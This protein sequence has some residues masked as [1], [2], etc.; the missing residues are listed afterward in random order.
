MDV[1]VNVSFVTP[2]PNS[3]DTLTIQVDW[4]DHD[5]IKLFADPSYLKVWSEIGA[6]KG[7]LLA[8][9]WFVWGGWCWSH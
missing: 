1:N 3:S 8:L 7:L 4:V 5:S 2:I 6:R 9:L